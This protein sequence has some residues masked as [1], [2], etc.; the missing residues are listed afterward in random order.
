MHDDHIPD[1]HDA[2]TDWYTVEQAAQ[3]W[4]LSRRAIYDAVTRGELRVA[5]VGI[6]R[7]KLVLRG[8]WIDDYITARSTPVEIHRRRA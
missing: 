7:R 6:G 5:R 3:R 1:P 4:P 8:S 2:T